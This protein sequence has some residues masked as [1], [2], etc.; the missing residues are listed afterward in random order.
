[1]K[2][3]IKTKE[4]IIEALEEIKKDF[5][6]NVG[7]SVNAFVKHWRKT[8]ERLGHLYIPR[9]IF[10]EIDNLGNYY[11]GNINPGENTKR[12]IKFIK[13]YLGGVNQ[14]YIKKGAFI[15]FIYR[16]GL[17]HQHFPKFM[18]YKRK[19]VGWAVSINLPH[20]HLKMRGKT[21]QID[22][23]KFYND[24]LDAIDLYKKDIKKEKDNLI[25]KFINAHIEMMKSKPKKEFLKSKDLKQTDF[26]FLKG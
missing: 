11:A 26:N 25:N 17:I 15:Y 18:S 13:N 10:P 6:D 19:N 14:E 2:K 9:L 4:E 3:D 23:E 16:H 5:K 24:F 12:A 1:M 8:E 22:A 20:S 7:L 21:I